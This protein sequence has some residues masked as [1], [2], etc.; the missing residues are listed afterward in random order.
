MLT[1]KSR[2]TKIVQG[3]PKLR[4]LAQYCD[5]KSRLEP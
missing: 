4:D 3:C 5:R 1:G 2:R